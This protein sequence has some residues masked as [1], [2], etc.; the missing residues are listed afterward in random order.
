MPI[1]EVI[2]PA[3]R[4]PRAQ[5]KLILID[6]I[7]RASGWRVNLPTYSHASATFSLKDRLASLSEATFV[8][9]DLSFESPS[10]YYE[11]GL[12]EALSKKVF[13]V[14]ERDARIFQTSHAGSVQT[15]SDM[16]DFERLCRR[17]FESMAS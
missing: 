7:A 12:T 4:D 8:L 2:F 17:I 5:E 13:V 9:A 1:A 6:S 11:L 15:Y 14:A 3:S 16:S 10:C